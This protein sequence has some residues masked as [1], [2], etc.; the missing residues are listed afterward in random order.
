MG[1]D[2]FIST[3]QIWLVELQQVVNRFGWNVETD[4]WSYVAGLFTDV[5]GKGEQW[6]MAKLKPVNFGF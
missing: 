2:G 6:I 4:G 3:N 5:D 1:N